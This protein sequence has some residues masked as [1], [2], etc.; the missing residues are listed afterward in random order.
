MEKEDFCKGYCSAVFTLGELDE[1]YWM[2]LK[3]ILLN[4]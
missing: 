3:F 1:N 4:G 2:K